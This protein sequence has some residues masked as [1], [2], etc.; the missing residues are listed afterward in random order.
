[1]RKGN[2]VDVMDW[3]ILASMGVL[4]VFFARVAMV[5]WMDSRTD[6][7]DTGTDAQVFAHPGSDARPSAA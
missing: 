4:V 7:S 2:V 5:E 3:V 1:M 6:R